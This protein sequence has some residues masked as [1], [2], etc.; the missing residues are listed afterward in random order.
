MN[1]TIRHATP[2]DREAIWHIM[3][4]IIR[5]GETYSLPR[6]MARE[7]A[8]A[9]WFAPDRSVFVAEEG[10]E[11]VGTC[12]LRANRPGP[13]AHVANAG[14]MVSDKA[15]GKGIG[16]ALCEHALATAK[17]QGFAAMQF[18]FVV[19]SNAS[20]V[21]LWQRMGFAEIGRAPEGFQHPRLGLVDALV[22]YRRL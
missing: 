2:N 16:Q 18:N 19:A 6:D 20:A 12:Y 1:G 10:D 14:F 22:M 13:G 3:E 7:D 9:H 21:R 5:V 15:G 8:L 11:I 17:A 4:P